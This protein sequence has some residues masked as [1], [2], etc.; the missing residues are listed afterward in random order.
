M[1]VGGLV[2]GAGF[3]ILGQ[4]RDSWQFLLFSWLL[5]V[6]ARCNRCLKDTLARLF[7]HVKALRCLRWYTLPWGTEVSKGFLERL[8]TPRG[9]P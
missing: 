5:V 6:C 3:L 1:I 4:A 8:W 9:S 2:S 7:D